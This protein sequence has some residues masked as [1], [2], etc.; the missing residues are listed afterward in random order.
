[1]TT[2]QRTEAE[3]AAKTAK[4]KNEHIRICLQEE[5]NGQH[6]DTGLDRLRFRHNALPELSLRKLNLRRSG[7]IR[8]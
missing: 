7:S 1:M 3:E 8:R 5:V 4:R 2:T 6:I